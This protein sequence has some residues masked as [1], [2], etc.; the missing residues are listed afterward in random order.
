MQPTTKPRT[1][2]HARVMYHAMHRVQCWNLEAIFQHHNNNSMLTNVTFKKEV[3]S[4]IYGFQKLL[5]KRNPVENSGYVGVGFYGSSVRPSILLRPS[6]SVLSPPLLAR[7][8]YLRA[9]FRLRRRR[10]RRRQ[11]GELNPLLPR[12]VVG[13]SFLL[14]RNVQRA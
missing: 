8:T 11:N 5:I 6:S 9:R 7:A 12:S 14:L 3:P 4:L 10:R 1:A 2:R 13:T